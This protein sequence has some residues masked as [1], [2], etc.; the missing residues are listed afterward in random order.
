MTEIFLDTL[1]FKSCILCVASLYF[2]VYW[3][4]F[5]NLQYFLSFKYLFSHFFTNIIDFC[6]SYNSCYSFVYV[7]F[8]FQNWL[9]FYKLIFTSK[10]GY[11]RHWKIWWSLLAHFCGGLI[12]RIVFTSINCF[13]QT[14]INQDSQVLS[15]NISHFLPWD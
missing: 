3:Q 12:F 1:Y 10:W 9:F 11:C 14:L 7:F 5:L 2:L 15:W 6:F 8:F 4:E 13:Y